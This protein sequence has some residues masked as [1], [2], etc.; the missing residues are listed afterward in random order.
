MGSLEGALRT[1]LGIANYRTRDAAVIKIACQALQQG[2]MTVAESAADSLS[3]AKLREKAIFRHAAQ[4]I[5][6]PHRPP[7]NWQSVCA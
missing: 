6:S 4:S 7:A 5:S 3:S 1:A 2:A